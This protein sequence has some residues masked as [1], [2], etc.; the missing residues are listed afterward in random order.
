[1]AFTSKSSSRKYTA[2]VLAELAWEECSSNDPRAHPPGPR[3]EVLHY[4]L[5]RI[6]NVNH[7]Q[8]WLRQDNGI[9][10]YDDDQR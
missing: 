1:M 10:Q 5:Q 2:Q 7:R 9:M 3:D 6:F 8:F 4:Y